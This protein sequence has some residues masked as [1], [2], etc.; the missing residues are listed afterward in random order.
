M[1]RHLNPNSKTILLIACLFSLIFIVACGGA[2]VP[3]D[4]PESQAASQPAALAATPAQ[5]AAVPTTAP[6][7]VPAD[8][9]YLRAVEPNAR[10]GGTLKW[11]GIASSTL[12]DLH[13]TNSI[14]NMGPQR[15]MYDLLVQLDP[16]GWE[17]VIPDLATGWD[18]SDDGMTYTFDIRE[19][20][21]FHDGA[22]LTADDVAASYTQIIFP[23]EGVL[24]PRKTLFEP[25][26]EIVVVD[27]YTVEFRLSEPRS[28]LLRAFSA[29]FNVIVRKQ[30]LEDN[31]YDLRRVPDYP[32]TGPF[33]HDSLE[34]GIVRRMVKNEDY[35]NPDL[36]YLDEMHAF[37]LD[38]GPK[39]GAACL[40]NT[41]D[42]CWG[43]DPVSARK[44]REIAGLSTSQ[45]TPVVRSG[46]YINLHREPFDDPRVRQAIN[47]VLDKQAMLD[48]VGELT[49]MYP[50]GWVLRTDPLFDEYWPQVVDQPGYRAPTAD[51]IAEAQRLMA[52]AGY[53]DG[54][55]GLDLMVRE[56]ISFAVEWG[57][58][59]QDLLQRHLKINADI[60]L[61]ASGVWYEEMDRGNW[62]LSP[63]AM[64]VVL[65]HV[66]DYWATGW[67]TGGGRNY[68]NYSNPEFDE[69]LAQ[70]SR[71]DDEEEYKQLVMRGAQIL[72]ED[73]PFITFGNLTIDIA[74]WNYVHPGET[75]SKAGNFWD[76]MRREIWWMDQVAN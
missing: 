66:G 6:A 39:T 36:P 21:T 14:A 53:A 67:K 68:N 35:W 37:H 17:E 26:Q 40:A 11:G 10:H 27:P 76:G 52:E 59:V 29:G 1:L 47:L 65:P 55:E 20:V 58:I 72:D 75:G 28:F 70:A 64:G 49:T 2:A 61:V 22:A 48:A 7:S 45:I 69:L 31:D 12:Y 15:P 54:Y 42:F 16:I 56:T 44:A 43:I 5:A 30:S 24:S 8:A 32:G 41:V 60:R 50:Q 38:L 51:D 9:G 63:I 25:V 33:K 23:R 19:G 73:L 57:P 46:M 13:Q 74:W 71:T 3:A 4:T 62:D 18:V 34:P